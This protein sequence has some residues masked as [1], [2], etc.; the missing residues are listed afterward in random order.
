MIRR[1]R[2][3]SEFRFQA[4]NSGPT[5]ITVEDIIYAFGSRFSTL[6]RRSS[7]EYEKLRYLVHLGHLEWAEMYRDGTLASTCRCEDGW[8]VEKWR[9]HRPM[10]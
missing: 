2:M 10:R 4:K 5:S 3:Q 1:K 6:A 7:Q 9:L 8:Y